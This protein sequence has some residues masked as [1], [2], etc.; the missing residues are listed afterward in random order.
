MRGKDAPEGRSDSAGAA[1]DPLREAIV[2]VSPEELEKEGE[3]RDHDGKERERVDEP[4]ERAPDTPR[5][6]AA[7][8]LGRR[9]VVAW[10][11]LGVVRGHGSLLVVG[12]DPAPSHGRSTPTSRRY[13][14]ED[15]VR[16]N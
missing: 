15:T 5:D 13:V 3:R 10:V 4:D 14:F 11:W 9:L 8:L 1:V 12:S 7:A 2:G 16:S 6:S